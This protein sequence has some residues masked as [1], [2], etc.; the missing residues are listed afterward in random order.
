MIFDG[1]DRE[2]FAQASKGRTKR[3]RSRIYQK[4][5]EENAK[6]REY[7][8]SLSLSS[9]FTDNANRFIVCCP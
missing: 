1:T 2:A 7:Q 4:V 5:K 8:D 9:N 3:A 6:K